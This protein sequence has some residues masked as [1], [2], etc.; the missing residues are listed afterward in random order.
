MNLRLSTAKLIQTIA[1][2]FLSI[3]VL[4]LVVFFILY[5]KGRIEFK[6]FSLPVMACFVSITWLS[7]SKIGIKIMEQEAKHDENREKE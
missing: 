6:Y 4:G 2:L 1:K 7:M 3:S 5:S